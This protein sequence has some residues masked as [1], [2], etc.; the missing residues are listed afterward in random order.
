[1]SAQMKA[2]TAAKQVVRTA[3]QIPPNKLHVTMSNALVN[4]AQGLQLSEK[5][6]ISFAVAKLD[7]FKSDGG[8][9]SGKVK[10]SAGDYAEAFDV[11]PDTAYNQL[12][13]CAE[14][15][16]K[17]QVTW[18]EDGPKGPKKVQINWLSKAEY[19]KGEG[20]VSIW[21]TSHIQP[22]LVQLKAKFTSY[23]LAQTGAL[24]SLY[25]WRLL[26]LLTQFES[27]GFRVMSIEDF[28]DVME[29]TEKQ[30][31]NFAAIRRKIIEPAVKELVEKDG[32]L[33]EWEPVKTGRKVTG[34]KFKFKRNPQGSLF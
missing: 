4:S 17:K 34:L 14:S 6:V 2:K 21:F 20:V 26:E 16:I 13:A 25:S 30:R 32:W 15:I 28:A 22:H 19:S 1:M 27:T 8:T 23:K 31:E 10:L 29:A 24:R 12:Q 5:R 7:S 3:H 9:V 33:I 18:Y 11:D